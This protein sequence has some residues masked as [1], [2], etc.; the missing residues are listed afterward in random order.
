MILISILIGIA[1]GLIIS[2]IKLI[3]IPKNEDN[4]N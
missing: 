3:S 1:I 2:Y 4:P